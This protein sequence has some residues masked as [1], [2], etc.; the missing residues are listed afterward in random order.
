VTKVRIGVACCH[1]I[2]QTEGAIS[3]LQQTRRRHCRSALLGA[4]PTYKEILQN[5]FAISGRQFVLA[6]PAFEHWVRSSNLRFHP[7][8][9]IVRPTARAGKL[10]VHVTTHQPTP[11]KSNARKQH[12]MSS[13]LR[14]IIRL[15]NLLPHTAALFNSAPR[16]RG[17]ARASCRNGS[18]RH[19]SSPGGS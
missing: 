15:A 18:T 14:I 19:I 16:L 7:N 5:V 1:N 6:D 3:T 10:V 4:W 9:L 8:D 11:G 2:T 13:D 17:R 12:R